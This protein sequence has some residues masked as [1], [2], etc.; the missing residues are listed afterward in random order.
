LPAAWLRHG[1]AQRLCVID[2]S[3]RLLSWQMAGPPPAGQTLGVLSCVA[4][5]VCGLVQYHDGS[6]VYAQACGSDLY[7]HQ[8]NA[9]GAP[10]RRQ[11]LFTMPPGD[12]VWF[13][14]GTAWAHGLGGCAVR[15]RSERQETWRIHQPDD[16]WRPS[17]RPIQVYS[18][19]VSPG[20]RVVG[21]V[22]DPQAGYALVIQSPDRMK[23]HLLHQRGQEPLYTAP[24]RLLTCSVCP[25]TGRVALLT[26]QRQF[27]VYDTAER[28]VR[29]CVHTGTVEDVHAQA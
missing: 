24:S 25:N 3:G 7:L 6:L 9:S 29:L 16:P 28:A 14:G 21:L 26:A 12:P 1:G 15:L 11:P 4:H 5:P 20:W 23:L 17:A 18:L 8:L 27:I 10:I 22:R 13:A 2:R 19:Q